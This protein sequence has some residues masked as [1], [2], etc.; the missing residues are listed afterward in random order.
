MAWGGPEE[1]EKECAAGNP[2]AKNWY[3]EALKIIECT[4]QE[5]WTDWPLVSK[6]APPCATLSNAETPVGMLESEFDRHCQM[7][8]ENPNHTNMAEMGWSE[9]LC[10]YLTVI[11]DGV[12]KDMDI[13]T[14]WSVSSHI[15]SPLC[16][17]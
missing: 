9:E 3:D 6:P 1:Q 14:W 5:Y 8:H 10:W 17:S 12:S 15:I 11:E 2:N 7:L 16:N 4:I 13:I